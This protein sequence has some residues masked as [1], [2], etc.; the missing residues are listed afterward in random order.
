MWNSFCKHTEF[1][2]KRLSKLAN[3]ISTYYKTAFLSA[4]M[5]V[6]PINAQLLIMRVE[7]VKY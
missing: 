6:H 5:N 4:S 3:H 2:Q 1:D 7:R